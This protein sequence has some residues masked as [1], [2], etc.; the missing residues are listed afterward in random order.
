MPWIWGCS[1]TFLRVKV[2]GRRVDKVFTLPG[3]RTRSWSR[4]SPRRT[5]SASSTGTRTASSS[6]SM[7]IRS[8]KRALMTCFLHTMNNCW[9]TSNI[10]VL[11]VPFLWKMRVKQGRVKKNLILLFEGGSMVTFLKI[12]SC[13]TCWKTILDT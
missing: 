4:S 11:L 8:W 7:S 3:E 12:Y 13:S 1:S 5:P 2:N 9:N 6:S 10:Y